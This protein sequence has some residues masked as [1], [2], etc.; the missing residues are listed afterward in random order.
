M[1]AKNQNVAIVD[2]SERI[3]KNKKYYKGI[4]KALIKTKEIKLEKVLACPCGGREFV[5]IT[6]KDRF[7]LPFSSV[8]CERCGLIITNPRIAEESLPRYYREI[9]YPLVLGTLENTI[10]EN[11][12]CENQGEKIFLYC[13][14]IINGIGTDKIKILEIGCASGFNLTTFERLA[15]E[16]NIICELWG[17]EY[18]ESNADVARKKGIRI[19]DGEFDSVKGVNYDLIIMSHV[20]EHIIDIN[21]C[22]QK[23]K[24]VLSD[25][26]L[27]YVEVPGLMNMELM[28]KDYNGNY[29]T[30][31]VHAHMYNF[32]LTSLGYIARINGYELIKGNEDVRTIFKISKEC[33]RNIPLPALNCRNILLHIKKNLSS[34]KIIRRGIGYLSRIYKKEKTEWAKK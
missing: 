34:R 24:N 1:D 22:L 10:M 2:D 6:N 28:E 17:T 20:L 26:G 15:R 19:I 21:A 32:N 31:S 7:G 14:D 12:V 9:Y 18:E 23:I 8:I 29:R 13:K 16:R 11:I 27:L 33:D 3:R 5:K 30:F 4:L 25:N